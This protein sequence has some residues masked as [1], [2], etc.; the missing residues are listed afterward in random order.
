MHKVRF[1]SPIHESHDGHIRRWKG[2]TDGKAQ[3]KDCG[4]AM[5]E[6]WRFS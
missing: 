4:W 5:N 6:N 3:V 2:T 1:H